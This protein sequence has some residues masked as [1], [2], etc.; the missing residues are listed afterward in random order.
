MKR[1]FP[2]VLSALLALAAVPAGAIRPT[3]GQRTSG[4][5]NNGPAWTQ[6]DPAAAPDHKTP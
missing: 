2:L 5:S 4:A 1:T 3:A 6:R